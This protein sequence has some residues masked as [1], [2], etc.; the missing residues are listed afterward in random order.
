MRQRPIQ[1][2]QPRP[3]LP[4][5]RLA[6]VA[7]ISPL[8]TTCPGS[9]TP[10]RR[11]SQL[12]SGWEARQS[13]GGPGINRTGIDDFIKRANHFDAGTDAIDIPYDFLWPLTGYVQAKAIIRVNDDYHTAMQFE[14]KFDLIFV[15]HNC[16]IANFLVPNQKPGSSLLLQDYWVCE[17]ARSE[18]T[19]GPRKWH[20]MRRCHRYIGRS[21]SILKDTS[22]Q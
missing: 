17:V 5:S 7:R 21:S 22:C 10:T 6:S 13:A 3:S 11:C 14:M 18:S 15:P 2:L 1:T 20:R 16:N 19:P 4:T 12:R 9:S 8:R